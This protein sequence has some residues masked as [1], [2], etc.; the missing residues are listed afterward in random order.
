MSKPDREEPTP[1]TPHTEKR[2]FPGA[3]FLVSHPSTI[4]T[5]NHSSTGTRNLDIHYVDDYNN[6]RCDQ[7]HY[8]LWKAHEDEEHLKDGTR[9]SGMNTTFILILGWTV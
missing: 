6:I 2:L 4:Q 7:F 9:E 5:R 3:V 8:R 1:S